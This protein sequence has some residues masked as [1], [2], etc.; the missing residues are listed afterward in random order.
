MMGYLETL[1]LQAGVHLCDEAG[2]SGHSETVAIVRATRGR[3]YKGGTWTMEP[4]LIAKILLLPNSSLAIV[5]EESKKSNSGWKLLRILQ[6][7]RAS[8]PL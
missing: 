5:F 2:A 7:N 6:I 1:V 8:N 3:S 4:G